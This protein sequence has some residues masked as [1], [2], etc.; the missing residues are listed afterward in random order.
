MKYNNLELPL[1]A[2]DWQVSELDETIQYRIDMTPRT[3][4][5]AQNFCEQR[6][7]HIAK[8][9]NST[10]KAYI[11]S[12]FRMHIGPPH[13]WLNALQTVRSSG[14]FQ[15]LGD[16]STVTS[17]IISTLINEKMLDTDCVA[18]YMFSYAYGASA[19]P[20][21]KLNAVVCE[22]QRIVLT[23]VWQVSEVNQSVQYLLDTRLRTFTDAHSFCQQQGGRIL[24]I[25]NTTVDNFIRRKY[26]DNVGPDWIWLDALQTKKNSGIF[27]WQDDYS[28]VAKVDWEAGQSGDSNGE[29]VALSLPRRY[30]KW[31]DGPCYVLRAVVCEKH[32]I[33]ELNNATIVSR[34]LEG[35]HDFNPSNFT[36]QTKL[37]QHETGSQMMTYLINICLTAIISIVL[38]GVYFVTCKLRKNVERRLDQT[39]LNTM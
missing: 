38:F 2:T 5:A 3:F 28:T 27:L 32:M 19:E 11:R 35:Y 10:V 20:C 18:V 12:K 29:C 14:I 7:G 30:N 26:I 22:K 15:W 13:I 31:R 6:R 33:V 1:L 9:T 23:N 37:E 16:N 25:S 17:M 34:L 21:S 39:E 36:D 8:I 24:K 4:T